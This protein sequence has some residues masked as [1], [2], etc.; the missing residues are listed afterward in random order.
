MI[1][2]EEKFK[3]DINRNSSK[4]NQLK[5]KKDN[6][7]YKADFLGYEGLAEHVVSELLKKTNVTNFV[8]YEL[9]QVNYNNNV[10]NGCKSLDFL[11]VN[12]TLLTLS[13]MFM[14]YLEQDIF[15]ECDNPLLDEA[16][17]AKYV[18][19]NVEDITGLQHFGKYLTMLLELDAFFLNEDRHFHNVAVIV[20]DD[21]D[22]F[23]Y[24]PVFDNGSSLFSDTKMTYPLEK[25]IEE[26]REDISSKPFSP[27]FDDQVE[28][29]ENLYGIQFQFWFTKED[30]DC[31]LN[32]IKIKELYLPE[33]IERVRK[34]LFEQIEKYI[35]FKKA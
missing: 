9:A 22:E 6:I 35:K 30:I 27:S 12:E 2:L 3:V 14:M 32:D 31:I 18:V 5:W 16:G 17:C 11:Q 7:W 13:K 29:L 20:N 10:Y 15:M 26:C 19:K 28:A 25:S 33:C 21:T 23:R 4:G 1:R 24:C 34:V 8:Q